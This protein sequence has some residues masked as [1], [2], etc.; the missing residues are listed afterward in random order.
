[1][2]TNVTPLARQRTNDRSGAALVM[3][4]I[5][6]TIL[7]VLIIGFLSSMSL[8]RRAA[9][10]FSDAE[11]AKLVAQGA[12]GHA[13]DLLRTNIPEPARLKDGPRSAPG[14]NWVT[15]PGRLTIIAND[16]PI[17]YVPL[18]T[19]EVT[20]AIDPTL[21]SDAESFDLNKPLPGE[22]TPMITGISLEP[23][24][25]RLPMRVR[26]VNVPA[27][28]SR[29]AAANN[30]LASRYA[31]WIDDE[32]TKLNF[33]T[34]IGKPAQGQDSTF[35][36]QLQ[37][38][39][40][41]PLFK[42][43]TKTSSFD[44][45]T[46]PE[47][48]LG[49][50]QSVNLDVLFDDPTNLDHNKL[51]D[52]VFLQGF[53]R[54]PEAILNYIKLT[55]PEARDWFDKSR[56]DLTFYNRSPEFNAFNRSRFFTTYVPL[57]IEAGPAY[58]HPFVF[59]PSGAYTGQ[60][61]SEVLHLNSLLGTFGFTNT[62]T[63][64]DGA[65][66]NGGN[67]VNRA[68]VEM[69]T[70]YFRRRWPGYN[71]SFFDKY[72]EAECR[73]LALNAALMARMATTQ[74]NNAN[75]TAF[76][77]QY[78]LRTTSVNF[79]PA[80]NELTGKT[81][82]RMYWRYPNVGKTGL[83]L[84]QTPGPHIT[85]VR[86]FV[87]S[88][89][90]SPAPKNDPKQLAGYSQPR[91]IRYW[92][93]VEYYMHGFGPIVDL[94][95]FPTRVDYFEIDAKGSQT[96]RQQFGPSAAGENRYDSDWNYSQ[97]N[98]LINLKRFVAQP[99]TRLGPLGAT[100]NGQPVSNRVVVRSPILTLGQRETVVPWQEG[101]D[102]SQWDP[103]VFDAAVDRSITVDLRI[104]PGMSVQDAPA[105]PRQMIPLGETREDALKAQFI[106]NLLET[107]RDLAMSWQIN[108]PRLS[109][110]LA[111]WEKGKEGPGTPSALGS[112]NGIG[113]PGLVNRGEPDE[114]S[115]EKSK[116]RYLLRAPVGS[117]IANHEIDR[118]DEYDSRSR[119]SSPG[120]W[121]LLHTG[122]QS[123]KPWQTLDFSSQA[124]TSS[125]PDWLILDLVAGTYPMASDQWKID[126]KQPDE[127][128]T[129]SFMNST[130]G[131]V[132]L[133][134]RTYPKT[135]FFKAPDRTRPLEGVF[136]NLPGIDSKAVAEQIAQ[137]QD[138]DRVFDYVGEVANIAAIGGVGNTPWKKE[139]ALRNLAGVLTTKTNT[140]GVWGVAQTVKKVTSN[141]KY[142]HFESGDQVL[143]EKRFYALV[144]RYVWPG[145]DGVPGNAH[146]ASG[147]K[148]DRLA[149]QTSPISA[150]GSVPDTLFQLPGSPPLFRS[151]QRLN[152]DTKG[153]YAE[154][155]GP[156]RVGMDP[157]TEAALGKVR[158][159]ASSLEEAYN[160]PQPTIKYRL[161]Y[162][163]Y[164]D[165]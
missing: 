151:G 118:P 26:W 35:D 164:L 48:A 43:G 96:K 140:F 134:T 127:F 56:Y 82:E 31:F 11:Q 3:T 51:L 65:S 91:Y 101:A 104:R 30:R 1:M 10:A 142:D 137:Y 41:T 9:V 107:N 63:D 144:E 2:E 131:Q 83:F 23:S 159:R 161:V 52:H 60:S 88:T 122:M 119:V 135:P 45:T 68:Q 110:D 92:Y 125:P 84:P 94:A 14:I 55:G 108:D 19:G 149:A 97:R 113:T 114:N 152:L 136:K 130:A 32:S 27:D 132:N 39:F 47:W 12:V 59:D 123:G 61:G 66:V 85:E 53:S 158:Y 139:F 57:S 109:S 16:Q 147:G 143:A 75:L 120:Y 62:V 74:I 58:Q 112:T 25:T 156:E 105:R 49:R 93:E 154:Y 42:R 77:K 5:T 155:D 95:E 46:Q 37:N 70:E 133:N 15:N 160:P 73:Q 145:R 18:H 36:S 20:E 163:K 4:L 98:D 103:F 24:T 22:T 81:P 7:V 157:F 126:Q 72:G 124:E 50:P 148:W 153:T 44:R 87:K 115:K 141:T 54:Y 129:A 128:S 64:E 86:L 111:E 8:E 28:P 21:P 121:S 34:A 138:D 80:S 13:I 67:V 89:E 6:L 76:S 99:A 117:R 79:S 71:R 69:L 90:A 146:I 33:N 116:F 162:F 38:D 150:S 17:R 78:S 102:S 165:Q 40:L 100:F 29:P 106:V